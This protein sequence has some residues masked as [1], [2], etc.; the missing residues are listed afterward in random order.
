MAA[1]NDAGL[2]LGEYRWIRS[3]MYQAIGAP[4]VDV[5]FTR[6]AADAKAGMQTANP[7][8][9]EGAFHG[10]AP[11]ANVKL[12]EKFKKQLEDNLALASFGL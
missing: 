12:V 5:D 8:S 2:S 10:T 1:L 6:I 11:A 3:S 4:Y 9:F 7:G